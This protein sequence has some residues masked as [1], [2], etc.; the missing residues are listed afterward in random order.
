M[1]INSETRNRPFGLSCRIRELARHYR[2]LRAPRLCR[3]LGNQRARQFWDPTHLVAEELNGRSIAK[4]PGIK[5]ACGLNR[6]FYWDDAILYAPHAQWRDEPLASFWNGPVVHVV[7]ALES[8]LR[9][10]K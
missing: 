1:K 9:N 2:V 8:A 10:L 4:R 7:P 5:P 6:G 3:R